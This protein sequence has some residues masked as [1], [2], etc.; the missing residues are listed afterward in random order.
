MVVCSSCGH[1][2]S[3]TADTWRCACGGPLS[4]PLGRGLTRSEVID[5]E[6]S[7]WRYARA[8]PFTRGEAAAFF[9]EG[10]TPLVTRA[11]AGERVR[12]KLDYLFP[13]GSYK[14]RGSAVLVNA[15]Q[16]EG[17]R[18][19]HED[20]SGNA[21]ASLATYA[22]AAGIAC[23]IYVPASTSAGKRVQIT[24]C[25]GRIVEVP[26]PREASAEAAVRAAEQGSRYASHNWHPYFV[27]GV[28]TLAYELWEQHAY[29]APDIV[30]AP[31]GY[32][33]VVLGLARGF[34]ELARAGAIERLPRIYGCQAAACAP[35]ARAFEQPGE[36]A[37]LSADDVA[38]TIAEG[39]AAARP[40]RAREVLDSIA[41]CDGRIVAVNEAEILAAWHALAT[42]GL[43]VEPTAA[44]APAAARNVLGRGGAADARIVVVLT[45]TGLK[46]TDQL[47]ALQAR[48]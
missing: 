28:K 19:V 4:L 13:S 38:A 29:A 10:M 25:G 12:F 24:A 26:G 22:A 43:Y 48:G 35:L 11:W 47:A 37:E 23:T 32:G 42:R 30:F 5:G 17:V 21:G 33:S 16:R 44:V 18:S 46:A 31:L 36:R 9:G 15:L 6:P 41:R 7:L 8:L 14:D 20:S 39:I 1:E 34:E 40:M 2:Q 27:E 3:R 45:G